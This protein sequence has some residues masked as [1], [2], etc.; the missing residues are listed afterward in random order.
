MKHERF[1]RQEAERKALQ[2]WATQD[3][4][5]KAMARENARKAIEHEPDRWVPVIPC[6]DEIL[7]TDEHPFCDDPKCP[8]HQD[9]KQFFNLLTKPYLDGLCTWPEAERLYD[10]KQI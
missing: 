8:C 6:E 3:A 5:I 4:E 9:S 1:V 7:H 10:G 2:A